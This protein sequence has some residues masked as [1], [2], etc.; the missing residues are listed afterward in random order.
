MAFCQET[1]LRKLSYLHRKKGQQNF[2]SH[3]TPR[4][5]LKFINQSSLLQQ[6]YECKTRKD[7]NHR[8][9]ETRTKHKTHTAIGVTTNIKSTATEPLP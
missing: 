6:Y 8:I 4:R 2:S 1:V 5:L 3:K 9:T 7:T